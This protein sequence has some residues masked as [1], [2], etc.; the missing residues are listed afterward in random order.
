MQIAFLFEI[1]LLNFL[2]SILR[3]KIITIRDIHASN[4][5]L[6]QGLKAMEIH[7]I[8]MIP[9][10]ARK[11]TFVTSDVLCYCSVWKVVYYERKECASKGSLFL[12]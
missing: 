1:R 6:L 4:Y 11:I 3:V 8:I 7:S 10:F 12:F 2:P 9:I 5:V